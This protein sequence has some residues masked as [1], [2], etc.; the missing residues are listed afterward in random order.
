MRLEGSLFTIIE[1]HDQV[2]HDGGVASASVVIAGPDR[3]SPDEAVYRIRLNPEHTIYKAHFP[4]LPI[5][6]GV[7]LVRIG[8]EL[9]G[10]ML[11]RKVRLVGAPNIKFTSPVYPGEG[12]ELDYIIGVKDSGTATIVV[13]DD[14]T[15]YSKQTLRYE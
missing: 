6:P 13:K 2:G 15:I 9:L 11:G 12:K 5:T 3:Q 4:E 8:V 14:E 7:I 1:M 10:K